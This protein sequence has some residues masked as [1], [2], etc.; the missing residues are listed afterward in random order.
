MLQA[1]SHIHEYITQEDAVTLSVIGVLQAFH[2][3][4]LCLRN[5]QIRVLGLDWFCFL[6]SNVQNEWKSYR[7]QRQD[8]RQDHAN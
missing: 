5:D 2:M 8:Q 4:P 6:C 3:S 1:K 7:I